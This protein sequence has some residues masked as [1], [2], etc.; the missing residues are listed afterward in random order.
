MEKLEILKAC[1]KLAVFLSNYS[2]G[3]IK[4]QSDKLIRQIDKYI[5]DEQ[6]YGESNFK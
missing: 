6:L 2:L 3:N 1:R 5:E 4:E